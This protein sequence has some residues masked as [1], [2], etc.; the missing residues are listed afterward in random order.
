VLETGLSN[1]NLQR[2]DFQHISIKKKLIKVDIDL[3]Q[4]GK[5]ISD[6]YVR[7]SKVDV[8]FPGGLIK[9]V[10]EAFETQITPGGAFIIGDMA[11]NGREGFVTNGLPNG[12]SLFMDDYMTSGEVAKFKVEDY[13][14]AKVILESYGFDVELVTVEDFIKNSGYE[15][16]LSVKDHWMMTIRNS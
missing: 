6:Y 16:P 4:Y 14:L 8:N 12:K 11:V 9:K 7:K 2:E 3:V 1:K 13:G 10:V 15:V 5:V